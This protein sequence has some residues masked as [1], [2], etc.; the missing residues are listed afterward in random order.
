MNVFA[1]PLLVCGPKQLQRAAELCTYAES[2][3]LDPNDPHRKVPGDQPE[4]VMR[5]GGYR[6]VFSV[7]L[8]ERGPER[9]LSMTP[10]PWFLLEEDLLR[11]E[12]VV[13]LFGYE[14]TWGHWYKYVD[15]SPFG[16]ALVLVQPVLEHAIAEALFGWMRALLGPL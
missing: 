4:H 5:F 13:R 11:M 15:Y 9:W 3:P 14:G 16:D 7:E 8:G 12:E 2:H 6:L 10:E 1:L